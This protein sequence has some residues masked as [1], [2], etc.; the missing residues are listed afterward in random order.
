MSRDKRLTQGKGTTKTELYDMNERII[1]AWI[2]HS[3][4]SKQRPTYWGRDLPCRSECTQRSGEVESL[5]LVY[6]GILTSND[7][8]FPAAS[9]WVKDRV[10]RSFVFCL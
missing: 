9:I 10:F 3:S 8:E 6:I 5:K 1:G 7:T 4:K 2:S